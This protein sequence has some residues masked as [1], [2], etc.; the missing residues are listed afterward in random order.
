VGRW[1]LVWSD[2]EKT[3]HSFRGLAAPL[4]ASRR[5]RVGE[6][7]ESHGKAR[8]NSTTAAGHG[9]CSRGALR[10][11]RGPLARRARVRGASALCASAGA[12]AQMQSHEDNSE[13]R[14][15]LPAFDLSKS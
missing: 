3:R 6:L 10:L 9:E 12:E 4:G 8:S 14:P 7:L 2:R 13:S 15:S 5:V 11:A 1:S